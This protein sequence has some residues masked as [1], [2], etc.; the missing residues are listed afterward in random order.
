MVSN[1]MGALSHTMTKLA[2]SL[3]NANAIKLLDTIYIKPKTIY[4]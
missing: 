1:L 2:L 4:V 3:A